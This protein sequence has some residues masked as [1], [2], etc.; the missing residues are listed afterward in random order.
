PGYYLFSD[1]TRIQDGDYYIR[2]TPPA[3]YALTIPNQGD[4]R[5]VDSDVDPVTLQSIT[6]TLE[7][8]EIDLSWDIGLIR[9]TA[10]GNYVWIDRNGDGLQ[11]EPVSDGMNGITVRLLDGDGE[12]VTTTVTADD[13]AGSPGYY[14]FSDLISSTYQIEFVLPSQS[15]GIFTFTNVLTSNDTLNSDANRI[16]GRTEVF[17]LTENQLDLTR[18]AGL[19]LTPGNLSLGDR[20]WRDLDNDGWYEPLA[21]EVGINDVRLSLYRDFN[22]NS[23]PDPGEYVGG[24][25]TRTFLSVPGYYQFNN[26]AAGTYIVVIDDDN[27]NA[28]E[29]LFGLRPSDGNAPVPDPDDNVNHDNNG[30][31]FAGVVRS[32]PITLAVGGEPTNDGDG[33]NGNQT[34]DFGFVGGAALGDRVWFDTNG[35]GL[36]DD[37]DDEPGM[38]GV[39]VELLNGSGTAILTTTTD[40]NGRYGFSQLISG[41]YRLR[42]SPPISHTFTITNSENPTLDSDVVEPATGL[43]RIFTLTEGTT[44][45]TWDAG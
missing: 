21:G 5:E 44:D 41:T 31:R 37:D 11:N 2:V 16:T 17:T 8:D 26:L 28:G 30:E 29:A 33:N 32:G 25:S 4:D 7:L 24:T 10:V 12:V 15:Q 40:L 45:L 43:T 14:L 22:N 1:P 35:N 38:A 42:F 27:F 9:Q 39:T 6:T 19:L 36:Q 34:L 23:E 20:V 3:G 13:P 18:D